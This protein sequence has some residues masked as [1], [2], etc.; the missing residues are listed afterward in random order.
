[1]GTAYTPEYRLSPQD[2]FLN[3]G[4]IFSFYAVSIGGYQYGWHDAV[5]FR[6]VHMQSRYIENAK[7]Q[8]NG[9]GQVAV[10]A[11]LL[12]NLQ[13]VFSV[14]FIAYIMSLHAKDVSQL[15]FSAIITFGIK[16]QVRCID[17]LR[18]T[19]ETA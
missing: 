15:G 16:R 4:R 3:R 11:D 1:M 9:V 19:Y 10:N 7:R 12:H 13:N 8:L 5:V 6:S 17:K 14:A 2:G 18:T